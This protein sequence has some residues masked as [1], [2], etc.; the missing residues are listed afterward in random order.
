MPIASQH[1]ACQSLS[2]C[3]SRPAPTTCFIQLLPNPPS[4]G[5]QHCLLPPAE[6]L[7]LIMYA[8]GTMAGCGTSQRQLSTFWSVPG[9]VAAWQ[10]LPGCGFFKQDSCSSTEVSWQQ[11]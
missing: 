5:L 2:P 6:Q 10:R 3:R 4:A 11:Y 8:D 1:T 7:L 9:G